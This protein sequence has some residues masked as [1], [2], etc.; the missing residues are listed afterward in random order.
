MRRLREQE[1]LKFSLIADRLGRRPEAVVARYRKLSMDNESYLPKR[2]LWSTEED[3]KLVGL[4]RKHGKKWST[5]QYHMNGRSAQSL[6]DRYAGY[7]YDQVGLVGSTGA[8]T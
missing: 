4:I 6:R 3:T 2:I 7:L 8:D 5:L 1:G